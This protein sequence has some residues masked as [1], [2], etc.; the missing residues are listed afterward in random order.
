MKQQITPGESKSNGRMIRGKRFPTRRHPDKRLKIKM[1]KRP[2]AIP[3]NTCA[4]ANQ[5]RD[6]HGQKSDAEISKRDLR[7]EP[8]L[9][10]QSGESRK[11]EQIKQPGR[12]KPD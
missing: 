11:Q 2:L 9:T 10:R 5:F 1:D 8:A 6:H 4:P 7:L 3:K 12:A